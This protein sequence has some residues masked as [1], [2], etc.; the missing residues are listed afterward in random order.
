M[1]FLI[2]SASSRSFLSLL[3]NEIIVNRFNMSRNLSRTARTE[4]TLDDHLR[5]NREQL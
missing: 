3:V 4:S 5:I 1:S 2:Q